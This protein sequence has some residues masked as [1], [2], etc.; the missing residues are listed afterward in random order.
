[1]AGDAAVAADPRDHREPA[2]PADPGATIT[3]ALEAEPATLDPLIGADAV[4]Q[5]ITM[6]DVY[7][8]LLGPGPRL[9]DAPVPRLA[10]RVTVGDAGRTW[11]LH[12]RDGVRWHDGAPLTGDDV[13]FTIDAARAQASWLAGDLEDLAAVDVDGATVVLR[14]TTARPDRA[15]AL[16]RLPILSRRA[17]AG[18]DLAT[19]GAL[20]EAA[21]SRAPVGTGPLR[22]VAWRGGDAI[23]LARWDRYWGAPAGAARIVYRLT[24]D[25][26]HALR[27]LAGGGVDVVVQLPRDEAD[28]FAADHPGVGRFGYRMPAFLAAILNTRRAALAGDDTRRALIAL[29]DRDGVARALLGTHAITGP[30]A[31][32]DPG[33]DP[34]VAAVPFDRA[35]AARLLGDARPTV[36]VLVPAGSTVMA[37]VA[38]IWASDAR[39]LATL[40]VVT[41]PFADMIARLRA[42]DFDVALTSMSTGPDVDLWSRLSS[43]APAEEAWTGLADPELDRLLAAARAEPD[44][45]RRAELRRGIHRRLAARLPIAFI[46]PDVRVGLARRDVGGVAGSPEGALRAAGLWRARAR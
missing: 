1:M 9:G 19:P 4:T 25:R 40:R 46:A 34:S 7:E 21:A 22:F 8:G 12:L 26:A 45:A 42:G 38:D 43:A 35:L 13:R 28:R 23:E 6:G 41:V 33:V 5:R 39:G 3:I 29:L 14:F 11:T 16:A 15:A 10:D 44:P 17:F 36:D 27:L 32:G 31:D 2:G 37:R 30:F 24:A 18:V 20:A